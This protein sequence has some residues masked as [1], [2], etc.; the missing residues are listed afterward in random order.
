MNFLETQSDSSLRLTLDEFQ[1]FIRASN[2]K[3]ALNIHQIQRLVKLLVE[4]GLPQ[5]EDFCSCP[6]CTFYYTGRPD[7]LGK[8]DFRQHSPKY[9][10]WD[11]R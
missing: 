2:K 3:V 10:P 7:P 4:S 8:T 9:H 6:S 1:D 11:S 5:M